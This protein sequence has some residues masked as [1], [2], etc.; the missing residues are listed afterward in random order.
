MKNRL[1]LVIA[2]TLIALNISMSAP[3]AWARPY[4]MCSPTADADC[5]FLYAMHHDISGLTIDDAELIAQGKEACSWMQHRTSPTALWDWVEEFGRQY[6]E[7]NSP[8]ENYGD[9]G[10]KFAKNSALAYCPNI[11]NGN[12][13]THW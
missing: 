7:Y 11:L 1:R 6:P 13:P 3:P 8:G 10:I 9:A 5:F 12:N 2:I 4:P